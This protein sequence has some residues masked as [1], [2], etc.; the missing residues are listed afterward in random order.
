MAVVRRSA[1]VALIFMIALTALV[2]LLGVNLTW[3]DI[4]DAGL[5][6]AILTIMLAWCVDLLSRTKDKLR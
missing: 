3:R 6:A 4:L 2:G 1:S 5:T